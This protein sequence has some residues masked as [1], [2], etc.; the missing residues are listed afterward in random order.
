[1]KLDLSSLQKATGSLE[2]AIE[3]SKKFIKGEAKTEEEKVIQAGVIQ[4]FEFTYELCWKFMQR[5]LETYFNINENLNKK[6]LFRKAF[7]NKLIENV[8]EWFKYYE[9]RNITSHTYDAAK[10][11][12]VYNAAKTFVNDAKIFLKNLEE[13]NDAK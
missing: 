9:A 6:E 7:E 10:A 11:E 13:V 4:N 8:P 2:S 5:A 12:T 1:M 3:V